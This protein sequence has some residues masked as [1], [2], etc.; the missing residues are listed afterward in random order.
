MINQN[1]KKVLFVTC[2]YSNYYGTDLGGRPSRLHHYLNSLKSLLNMGS[3]IVVYTSEYDNQNILNDPELKDR[4][5]LKIE[6]FDLYKTDYREYFKRKFE[7]DGIDITKSDRSYDV[8]HSKIFFIK[9]HLNENYDHIYWID[10]GLCYEGLM[11]FRY[12]GDSS[13]ENRNKCSLMNNKVP[14]NLLKLNDKINILV[15]DQTNHPFGSNPDHR[16]LGHT[17]KDNNHYVVGGMFGGNID[18]M[19]EFCNRYFEAFDEMKDKNLLQSEEH[20]LTLLYVRDLDFYN[21]ILFTTWHHEDSDMAQYNVPNE[22][23]FYSIFEDLNK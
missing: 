11:P 13:F 14:N 5:N 23:Y 22:K 4:P 19:K 1:E 9:N 15:A 20:L 16:L 3:D 10:C 18:L 21:P 6:I 8:M 12:R 17:V 7:E 2:L